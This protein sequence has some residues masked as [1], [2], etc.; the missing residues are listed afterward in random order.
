MRNNEQDDVVKAIVKNLYHIH[1]HY[2]S[3]D[4][5]VQKIKSGKQLDSNWQSKGNK[6]RDKAGK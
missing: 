1:E 5:M 6:T 2:D 3:F 4:E